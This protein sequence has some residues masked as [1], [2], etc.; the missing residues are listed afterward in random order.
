MPSNSATA[1]L[2]RAKRHLI[3]AKILLGGLPSTYWQSEKTAQ[4][5]DELTTDLTETQRKI[6]AISPDDLKKV[7]DMAR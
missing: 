5:I 3:A 1:K 6:K 4:I 7:S 2:K